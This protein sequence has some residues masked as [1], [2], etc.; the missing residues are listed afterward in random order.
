[1]ATIIA[2]QQQ[3]DAFD[4][5]N[6]NIEEAATINRMLAE[7]EYRLIVPG[8]RK[9]ILFISAVNDKISAALRKQ[10]EAISRETFKLAEKYRISLDDR[11]ISVLSSSDGFSGEAESQVNCT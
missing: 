3:I 11:D 5:I 10:K 1:M 2:N 6:R 9:T 4:L 8:G 7:T